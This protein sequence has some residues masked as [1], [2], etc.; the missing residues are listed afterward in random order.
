MG[1]KELEPAEQLSCGERRKRGLFVG[2]KNTAKKKTLE[3]NE[4]LI[5]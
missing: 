3:K 4:D 1:L 2:I 5:M